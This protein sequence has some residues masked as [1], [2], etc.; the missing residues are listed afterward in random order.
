M[1]IL[2]STQQANLFLAGQ[3]SGK[4][5]TMGCLSSFFISNFP[6]IKGL[7]AANTN[8]QLNRS[9]MYR[10][11]E[12]WFDFFGLTEWTRSNN[13]GQYTV[14]ITPPPHFDTSLHNYE[15]Y[16]NI[17]SFE[18]G[19]VIFIGSL[20]NYKALDGLEV[21]WILLDETKD[22]RKEAITEVLVG[23]LRQKGMYIKNGKINEKEGIEFNPFYVFTSPAKVPWLNEYF[24]LDKFQNEIQTT[25]YNVPNYF[26]K[27]FG[28]RFIVISATHLNAKN[29]PSN[30][31]SNQENNIPKHLQGMLI[32]GDPFGKT[33]GEF[34]KYF[35]KKIHADSFL[36]TDNEEVLHL[37]FDFNSVPYITCVVF[38]IKE[39]GNS[40]VIKQVNEIC[41]KNPK[42]SSPA[43]AEEICKIYKKH[44]GRVH[45]YGD[46]AGKHGNKNTNTKSKESDFDILERILRTEFRVK[47]CVGTSA[48]SVSNS[49]DFLNSILEKNIFE[50]KMQISPTCKE[51][52][53]DYTYCKEDENGN[54]LKVRIK[55]EQTSVM[56]EPRGHCLDATRYF[57]TECF[58]TE[59]RKF[60]S[61]GSSKIE[62]LTHKEYE[63]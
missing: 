3:G 54:M 2:R 60:I 29:L 19:A 34:I 13:K 57:L 4:T 25:I 23:R 27:D 18:W 33:G 32:F 16:H 43:L 30:Y 38:Q 20:E 53:D 44:N 5:F 58:K 22:T 31:I 61:K 12:C 10:I 37:S 48:P 39:Q 55:D 40:K 21:G 6:K 14:G 35:D 17:I 9:T 8:D 42:N 50:L 46:P 51:T 24:G 11:R 28:N 63:Y 47:N 56:Y 36:E 52:I 15:H 49:A 26:K 62:T 45:I 7:I 59:Y 41:L 1:D